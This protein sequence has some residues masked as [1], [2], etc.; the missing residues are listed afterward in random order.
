MG[1][2]NSDLDK[3][4]LKNTKIFIP[5]IKYGKVVKVYDGDTITNISKYNK[6]FYKFS[7]RLYGVDTPELRTKNI[8]EK[9]RA[10]FVRNEL[11]KKILNKYV[12]IKVIDKKEKYGR[13]LCDIVYDGEN[14]REWLL[15]NS[16]ANEYYGGKKQEFIVNK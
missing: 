16:Y 5:N 13:L 12:K 2:C 14:I 11:R 3:Y 9:N 1:C 6:D 15:K 4:D 7:I 8:E 10:I